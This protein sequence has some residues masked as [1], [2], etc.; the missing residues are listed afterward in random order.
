MQYVKYKSFKKIQ[1]FRC[2][3]AGMNLWCNIDGAFP[4]KYDD[5]DIKGGCRILRAVIQRSARV[6]KAHAILYDG[7]GWDMRNPISD[8]S[9]RSRSEDMKEG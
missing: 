4:S 6:D 5:G 1:N 9:E 3:F 7:G 8:S 2:D